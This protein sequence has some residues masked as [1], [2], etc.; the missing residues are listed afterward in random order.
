MNLDGERAIDLSIFHSL[1]DFSW[2]G[3]R[4]SEEF[5]SLG[6][7]LDNNATHLVKLHLDL[8]QWS[9][10]ADFNWGDDDN[11]RDFSIKNI[12]KLPGSKSHVKF[13]NLENLSLSALSFENAA[14]KMVHALNFSCLRSLTLR[15]CPFAEDF[16]LCIIAS[17]QKIRLKSLEIQIAVVDNIF[18]ARTIA[19]L[20]LKSNGLEDIFVSF[21][22]Q[23]PHPISF[24]SSMARHRASL[25]RFVC[26]QMLENLNFESWHFGEEYDLTDMS[27]READI[28]E[29]DVYPSRH[30]FLD[31]DLECL[32]LCCGTHLLV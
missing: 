15:R 24:L 1:Q 3:L 31:L 30:P 2:T 22:G 20:I 6:K 27:M 9:N 14:L 11:A 23:I 8:V 32:G 5:K 10:A 16:L 17:K 12:L 18:A 4:F 28:T 19:G 29:L 13:S 7:L 25:K 26:Q 21:P